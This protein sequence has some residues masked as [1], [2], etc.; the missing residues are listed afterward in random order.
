MKLKKI[1]YVILSEK[2]NFKDVKEGDWFNSGGNTYIKIRQYDLNEYCIR[3]INAINVLHGG[4]TSF[5]FDEEV[6]K[7]IKE[8]E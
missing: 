4:L 1:E 5:E 3:N 7:V 6:S 8:H 2:V